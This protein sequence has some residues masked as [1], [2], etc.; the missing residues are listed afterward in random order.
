MQ[1][2]SKKLYFNQFE[3]ERD[4]RKEEEEE[5]EKDFG[6]MEIEIGRFNGSKE[7]RNARK[8][9]IENKSVLSPPTHVT[10]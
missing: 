7:E 1:V 5:L 2:I 10:L 8:E 4:K 6:D 3:K 9:F